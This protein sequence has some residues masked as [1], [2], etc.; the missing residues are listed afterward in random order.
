MKLSYIT[1]NDGLDIKPSTDEEFIL[2]GHWIKVFYKQVLTNMYNINSVHEV[3]IST[4][5]SCACNTNCS[6]PEQ[7]PTMECLPPENSQAAAALLFK[8]LQENIMVTKEV[9]HINNRPASLFMDNQSDDV[10]LIDLISNME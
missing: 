9:E 6:K 10:K 3:G 5:T 8:P 4:P 1:F 2:H 7:R